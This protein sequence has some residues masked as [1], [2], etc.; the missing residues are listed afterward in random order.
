MPLCFE[1]YVFIDSSK[2]MLLTPP[3]KKWNILPFLFNM[4]LLRA[5]TLIP[6]AR[7]CLFQISAFLQRLPTSISRFL[8]SCLCSKKRLIIKISLGKKKPATSALRYFFTL[9]H[10]FSSLS[11]SMQ[12]TVFFLL[13]KHHL[14][15]I[16]FPSF[17]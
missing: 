15:T 10:S 1:Y 6:R 2:Q 4:F 16:T 14:F 17:E 9:V 7:A 12:R 11:V 5:R 3:R 8:L 13:E